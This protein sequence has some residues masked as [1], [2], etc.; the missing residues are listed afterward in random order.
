MSECPRCGASLRAKAGEK[1]CEYCGYHCAEDMIT[2]QVVRAIKMMELTSVLKGI[3]YKKTRPSAPA[4]S[5]SPDKTEKPKKRELTARE[6]AA[7]LRKIAENARCETSK[8]LPVFC[9]I[10]YVVIGFFWMQRQ[11]LCAFP[12]FGATMLPIL[13]IVAESFY[14]KEFDRGEFVRA[15]NIKQF[16]IALKVLII[17]TLAFFVLFLA[18]I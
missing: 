16:I 14:T 13:L 17:I 10:A 3:L 9:M 15:L 6:K 2:L 18:I 11:K 1:V 12:V 5:P 7:K 4:P 8:A